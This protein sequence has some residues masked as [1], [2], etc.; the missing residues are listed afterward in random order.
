M[1]WHGMAWPGLAGYGIAWHGVAWHTHCVYYTG[2]DRTPTLHKAAT[3]TALLDSNYYT[4][5]NIHQ[6]IYTNYYTPTTVRYYYTPIVPPQA[7]HGLRRHGAAQS[8]ARHARSRRH[9]AGDG[10]RGSHRCRRVGRNLSGSTR[11]S[12][13]S[14]SSSS[15]RRRSTRSRSESRITSNST[16]TRTSTSTS[17]NRGTRVTSGTSGTS[18]SSREPVDTLM[19]VAPTVITQGGE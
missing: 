18:S 19:Q 12:T 9:P 6:L 4:P 8:A 13:M 2:P 14:N 11:V 1:T 15:S 7:R 10:A 3:T 17:G 16:S 5:N